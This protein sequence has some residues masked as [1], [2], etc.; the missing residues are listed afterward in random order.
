[1]AV[2]RL[3]VRAIAANPFELDVWRHVLQAFLQHWVIK[4]YRKAS[5]KLM[6]GPR[7]SSRGAET[8]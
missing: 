4:Y 3:G 7:S 1:M 2:V 5:S 6:I 8:S